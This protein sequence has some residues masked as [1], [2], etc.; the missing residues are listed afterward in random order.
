LPRIN[1]E[2]ADLVFDLSAFICVNPRPTSLTA[3][4]IF[5]GGLNQIS[6]KI[7]MEKEAAFSDS[8]FLS[9]P[10]ELISTAEYSTPD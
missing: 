5:A 2:N 9:S 1:A 6:S 8:L 10:S 4:R 3:T 7:Q